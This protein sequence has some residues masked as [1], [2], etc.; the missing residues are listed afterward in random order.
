MNSFEKNR[1]PHMV[2]G[3]GTAKQAGAKFK[4]MG[5]SKCLVVTDKG[6]MEVGLVDPIVESLKKEGI[7]YVIY[8]KTLPNPPDYICIEVAKLLT[9]AIRRWLPIVYKDPANKEARAQMAYAADMA[10]STGGAAN[11]H[12]IAHAIG[13]KYNLVH[14]HSCIM[15]MPTLIRHQANTA[16][17]GIR[18]LA[19][20]FSVPAIGTNEEVAGYV[21]DAVLDFYKSFGFT[22]CKEAIKASGF[23]DDKKTFVE[24]L[25]PA[26]LDD[27]K[28]QLFMPPIHRPE[29]RQMLVKVCEMIYDEE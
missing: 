5:C 18:R 12:A 19:D 26:I 22:T 1:L 27:Y 9:D 29:D 3:E 16:P 21:A 20:I 8:D 14:G 6:V 15:V 2:F 4:A 7:D 11:G 10:E 13:S 28:S 25:I 23:D 24:N 17:E